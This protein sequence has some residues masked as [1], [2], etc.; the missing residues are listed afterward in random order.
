[1][2][3]ENAYEAGRRV[4]KAEGHNGPSPETI[5]MV[6]ELNTKI[7]VYCTKMEDL[8]QKVSEGFGLNSKQHEEIVALLKESLDKKA[9]K[10]VESVVKWFLLTVG[11]GVLG[12]VGTLI[13]QAIIHFN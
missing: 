8:I 1:M 11:L 13:Y 2:E 10:W 5:K 7:E 3:L 4:G 12:V 6:G 9:D